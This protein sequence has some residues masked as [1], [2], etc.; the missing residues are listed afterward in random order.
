[1]LTLVVEIKSEM[2]CEPELLVFA[3]MNYHLHAAGLLEHLKGKA[4]T[5]K[6]SRHSLELAKLAAAWADVSHALKRFYE[7]AEILIVL[8]EVLLLEI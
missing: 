1:M 8:D 2:P 4:P 5:P 6:Q 3:G 7:L